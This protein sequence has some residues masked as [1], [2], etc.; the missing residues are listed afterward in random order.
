MGTVGR[1]KERVET[2][3]NQRP[4][5][6]F[7][8]IPHQESIGL[9]GAGK[10]REPTI[11]KLKGEYSASVL[12]MFNSWCKDMEMCIFEW[13]HSNGE[14]IQLVSLLQGMLT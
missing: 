8:P 4:H 3:T 6:T 14:A 7:I 13:S 5:V 9:Q 10:M 2:K 11:S 1:M 12:L